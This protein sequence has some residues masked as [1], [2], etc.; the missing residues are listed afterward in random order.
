MS[1]PEP[2]RKVFGG[3]QSGRG[4][5]VLDYDRERPPPRPRKPGATPRGGRSKGSRG[6][7]G[8]RGRGRRAAYTIETPEASSSLA[9]WQASLG[10]S[11]DAA[12]PEGS[13]DGGNGSVPS[14]LAS[15][16]YASVIEV[17]VPQGG[18]GNRQLQQQ[19]QHQ[20]D[21]VSGWQASLFT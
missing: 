15:A 19:Q 8:G 11:Y 4:G 6:G 21:E 18:G 5:A 17:N 1:A 20:G 10:Q 2:P 16:S 9:P 7:G 12:L 3:A 14:P 13:N